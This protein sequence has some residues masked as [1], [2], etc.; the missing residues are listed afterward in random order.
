MPTVGEVAK[1][2]G[3]AKSTV[4]L[5]LNNKPGVSEEMRH[6]VLEAADELRAIE[7]AQSLTTLSADT[8]AVPGVP[9]SGTES[10]SV[11]VLH[12]PILRSS[13]VFSELLQGIQAG[14]A[15]HQIQLRLAS[16]EPDL[17]KDHITRL[18][19][20]VPSLRPSGVLIIG[21]RRNE[22]LIDEARQLGIPCV[23]VGRQSSDP[24]LAAVGRDEEEITFLAAS[25]LLDMGHRAIAFVG[26]DDAY[27]Y[28]HSRL[29][30]YRRALEQRNGPPLER[31][32]ALGDGRAAAERALAASPEITAVI[33]IND[34][35]AME[36]LPV[37]QATGR[38][39]PD[40]LS[41]I[42]FDDTQE[43]GSFDPPLT[44]VSYPRFQEGL[45]SVKV[46]VDH[47]R[48]PL[49]KSCQIV[50]RASLIKRDSCAPPL[51]EAQISP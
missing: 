41:V 1:H 31:W 5:V 4:S 14:A 8:N 37:F 23:L 50:F 18:Y 29:N 32:I 21:A 48:Q 6:R 12:P 2:A 3:V 9:K 35:Y 40:D 15:S 45:W 19:L 27:S 47:I 49:M 10:L 20:S 28:T 24:T 13:Q 22:P 46:L 33:F 38:V 26:G 44:S 36:G 51:K 17:P 7:K 11:V 30:G 34:A 39:I 25:Y 43:A 16:N 42:S